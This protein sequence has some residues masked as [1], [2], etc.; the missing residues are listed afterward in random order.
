MADTDLHFVELEEKTD[1]TGFT[2]DKHLVVIRVVKVGKDIQTAK[3]YSTGMNIA[4]RDLVQG[5]KKAGSDL[6]M[7][8]KGAD[9]TYEG[10]IAAA[11]LAFDIDTYT[12][13]TR[14]TDKFY[15]ELGS[16]IQNL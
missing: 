5:R 4:T 15:G 9:I 10:S 2:S 7:G 11:D 14:Q 16:Y 6:F 8:Q 3:D 13:K 12:E 1:P